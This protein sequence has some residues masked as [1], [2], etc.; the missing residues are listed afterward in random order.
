MEEK[1]LFHDRYFMERLLGRGNFSEVWL[2]R[3]TKTDIAVALKI[4]APA[5]GLDDNGLNVF[6]REFALVVNANHKNL[7]KPLY[8]DNF[9][10]K[11]YLVLPYC[12]DGS[13]MRNVGKFTEE[14]AWR[15]IR[16]VASG[17]SWLHNMNPPVIHQDIKPD[18]V[19]IGENGDF[20]ITDFGVSTHLKS[21]L[22]KSMSAAFSSAGTIAYMAPERFGKDNTPI[23]ANDIYSLGATVFEML[24]GDT[25]FGNDGGLVQKKGA[26]VPELKGEYSSQLKKVISKCL[27]TNAWERPTA[28]QLEKYAETALKGE[29][30]RFID[31]KTFVQKN[32]YLIILSIIVIMIGCIGS[33]IFISNQKVQKL[34]YEKMEL[35]VQR[36]DSIRQVIAQYCSNVKRL[37]KKGDNHEEQ[38]EQSYIE[39]YE[40]IS[41]AIEAHKNLSEDKGNR[42][43]AELTKT[44]V[45]IEKKL[46]EAFSDLNEKA[47]LFEADD[48]E[49]YE[50]FR[51]RAQKVKS[52]LCINNK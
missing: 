4:Y 25:P 7:L 44:K 2:A 45:Q 42:M 28:E 18:N 31:E 11:P 21:T 30:I 3:D 14:E 50:E 15:L 8:Y 32:K 51:Q 16:D 35:Q 10:R 49:V 34:E 41:K 48:P 33:A 22:R 40:T 38:Y 43:K 46:R 23:M 12:K 29:V 37:E 24:T 47:K 20:M 19:M 13:I 52:S 39:A 17:L 27:R 26:D 5:T 9:E 36:N 1:K 6:A